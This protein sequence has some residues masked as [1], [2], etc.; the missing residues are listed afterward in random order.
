MPQ[1]LKPHTPRWFAAAAKANLW[2]ALITGQIVQWARSKKV[3]SLCGNRPTRDYVLAK[4][5]F[6]KDVPATMRLCA[7]CCQTHK[8]QKNGL[9]PLMA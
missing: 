4:T 1:L 7:D 9:S 3:C 2:Q 6:E 8:A 5:Q